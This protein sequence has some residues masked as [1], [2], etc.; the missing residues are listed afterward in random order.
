[1][2]KVALDKALPIMAVCTPG[3]HYN[4]QFIGVSGAS[5]ITR[6]L[7]KPEL[8]RFLNNEMVIELIGEEVEAHVQKLLLPLAD[9]AT[10]DDLLACITED[11]QVEKTP[12]VFVSTVHGAKGL[13]FEN[14]ILPGWSQELF[15]GRKQG[16]EERR[17]A[18][19]GL[20]RAKHRAI[21]TWPRLA[22]L[23]PGRPEI[24]TSPST[25]IRE[26]QLETIK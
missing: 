1:L 25:F 10:I 3:G 12:G 19:V 13:E 18:F 4:N 23:Y 14:V 15:P 6:V 17:I 7:N 2:K 22:S 11:V 9:D 21:I 5:I 24:V 16:E 26:M 20:T 8:E